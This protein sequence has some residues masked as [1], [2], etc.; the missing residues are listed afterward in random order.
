MAPVEAR[1]SMAPASHARFARDGIA[2]VLG[3]TVLSIIVVFPDWPSGSIRATPVAAATTVG[4]FDP[5]G[6]ACLWQTCAAPGTES[7]EAASP[8]RRNGGRSELNVRAPANG[9]P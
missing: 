4:D 8:G 5:T 6:R 3:A 2:G 7:Y 9:M 1:A